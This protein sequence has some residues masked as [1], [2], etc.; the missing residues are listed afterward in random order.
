MQV[1]LIVACSQNNGIGLQNQL[2]WKLKF[3]LRFFQKTTMETSDPLKQNAIIM[4]RN[5]WD[6]LPSS[7]RPLKGRLNVVL[8]TR[9]GFLGC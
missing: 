6:S 7:R 5:T 4:G 3:D 8:S 9:L 2:P 1:C